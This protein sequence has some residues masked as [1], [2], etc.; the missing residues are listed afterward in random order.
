[1]LSACL[2]NPVV[3]VYFLFRH[4]LLTVFSNFN[5]VLVIYIRLKHG[6][7]CLFYLLTVLSL[8]YLGKS[9]MG[10]YIPVRGFPPLVTF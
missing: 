8:I 2:V 3:P 1:M 6:I 10:F 7:S 4:L 5:R 9:L